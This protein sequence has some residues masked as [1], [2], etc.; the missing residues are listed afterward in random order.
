MSF[1]SIFRFVQAL[2]AEGEDGV[3]D[4]IVYA[5][6][7]GRR[8]LTNAAF[9]LGALMLLMLNMTPAAVSER[10][11]ASIKP[12]SSPT[13]TPPSMLL[14]WASPFSTAGAA[15]TVPWRTAGSAAV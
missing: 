11:A 9:L 3:S 1:L 7:M 5:A 6:E 13:E 14:T 2:E 8:P 4:A 12:S 10:F 15:S